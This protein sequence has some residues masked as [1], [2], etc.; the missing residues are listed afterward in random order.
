MDELESVFDS[1]PTVKQSGGTRTFTISGS[2]EK[3][4]IPLKR[5]KASGGKPKARVVPTTEATSSPTRTIMTKSG[6]VTT[7]QMTDEP[8][9]PKES[10]QGSLFSESGEPIEYKSTLRTEPLKRQPRQQN[11]FTEEEIAKA[12]APVK[13]KDVADKIST[14]KAGGAFKKF[15][16]KALGLGALGAIAVGTIGNIMNAGGRKTNAQLYSDPYA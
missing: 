6:G 11:L 8:A 16:Y 10:V 14:A 12:S 15:G 9:P 7:Y 5:V 3:V 13:P 4:S 1:E 2:D